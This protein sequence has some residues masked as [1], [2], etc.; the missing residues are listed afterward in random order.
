MATTNKNDAR[1]YLILSSAGH[2]ALLPL[3]Y[4]NNLTPLKILS[5][6]VYIIAIFLAF[7]QK[8]N[9]DL[10]YSYEYIYVFILPILTIYETI[11]HKIIFGEALPFL[12]LALISIY[13]A[14]G[15]IYSW[16]LYYYMFLQYN[17][18]YNQKK[19]VE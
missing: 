13:C 12:P 19:K 16:I 1:I 15:I 5:L 4:L 3:L 18:I 14:I 10:L 8:F 2:T 7:C 11:I 9:L 17:K 6:L